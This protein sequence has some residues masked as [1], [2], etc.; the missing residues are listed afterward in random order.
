VLTM[1]EAVRRA[2]SGLH[3]VSPRIA[4]SLTA[5]LRSRTDDR[6]GRRE[7]EGVRLIALGYTSAEVA[8]ELHLSKRT[9]E[10]H[11]ERINRKLGLQT[12]REPVSCALRQGLLA[13]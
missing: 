7:T 10:T 1:E 3:S 2:A 6:Y 12:R 13:A 8:C 9:V 5:L 11:R 4:P